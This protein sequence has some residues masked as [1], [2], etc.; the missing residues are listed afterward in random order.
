[1]KTLIL[2]LEQINLILPPLIL[3]NDTRIC[4]R[5]HVKISALDIELLPQLLHAPVMNGT[6]L[7]ACKLYLLHIKY[8]MRVT[9]HF[10]LGELILE[11]HVHAP[12]KLHAD[13]AFILRISL[14]RNKY[15]VS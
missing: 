4:L 8:Y 3:L 15:L 7:Y 2:E 14:C 9:R 1:M 13:V 12:N 5:D 10:H 6:I 11:I